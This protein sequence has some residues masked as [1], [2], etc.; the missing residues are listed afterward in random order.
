MITLRPWKGEKSTRP[1]L[2][3]MQRNIIKFGL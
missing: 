3:R 2:I 1:F